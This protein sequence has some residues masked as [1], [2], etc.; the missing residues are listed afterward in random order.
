MATLE[1]YQYVISDIY[2]TDI[3]LL[4]SHT[5]RFLGRTVGEFKNIIFNKHFLETAG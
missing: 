5:L 1:D 2:N 3:R 4:Q